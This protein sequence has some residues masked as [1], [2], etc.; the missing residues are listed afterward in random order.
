[1]KVK[2]S[3]KIVV[4]SKNGNADP[5]PEVPPADTPPADAPPKETPP[6][7]VPEV[8][9]V[10]PATPPK[11][12]EKTLEELAKDNPAVAKLLDD[13]R[14]ADIDAAKALEDEAVKNGDW[15][16]LAEERGEK[17]TELE[18]KAKNTME[19]LTKYKGSLKIVL[20]TMLKKVSE[21][22]VDLIPADYSERQKIEYISKNANLLGVSN[23]FGGDGQVPSGDEPN[24][25]EELKLEKE[26]DELNGKDNLTQPEHELLFAK[27][28]ALKVL[29]EKKEDK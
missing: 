5:V 15:K 1:M 13:K 16:K 27:S 28:T 26:I 18:G 2:N 29:R 20:D 14:Q 17:V 7:P 3:T 21:D 22:K 11:E 24:L 10:P 4:H 9:A 8:P 19:A 6:A 12:D 23:F 25:S